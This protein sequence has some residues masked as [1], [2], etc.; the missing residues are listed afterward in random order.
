MRTACIAAIIAAIL[1]LPAAG[2]RASTGVAAGTSGAD[3]AFAAAVA[4]YVHESEQRDPLFA[5]SLGINT[6]DDRLTDYSAAAIAADD[7][8]SAAWR[9]KFASFDPSSLNAD[10]A[11]DRRQVLDQIDGSTFDERAL[12]TWQTD[13]TIYVGAIGD[14]A[15]LLTS[16]TYASP[17]VRMRS[18]LARMPLIPS[19]VKDAEANLTRPPLVFTQ[20]AIQQNLGNID[21]YTNDV[22]Q[23]A[24][25]ASPSLHAAYLKQLPRLLASLDEL[26]HFLTGPLLQR[27]DGNPRVGA[28][29]FAR[30]L[31]LV[32]GTDTPPSVLVARAKQ[33]FEATRRQMLQLALPLDKQLFPGKVHHETGDALI[34]A[35]VG[36][37]LNRLA[38]DHPT[39]DQ[40][41]DT[42][43]ADVAKL[44]G[45]LQK[46]PVVPLPVP[47][48][49]HVVPTPPFAA[50]VAGAGLDPA[51][52]FTPLAGSNY[53]IDQIPSAWSQ[54]QVTSYLRDY[55]D[56]E[57]QILSL[58][59]A[60][61]GHYVQ[62]RYNAAVPSLV[63]RVWPNGSFVE[64][65]AVYTEGMMLDSG[66]G[67]GDPRLKLFQL[68][69]RLRE[70]SNTIIDNEYHTAGLTHAQCVAFLEQGA[71]QDTAQAETKWHRLEVSHDQLS[72]Y[73]VGLDAITQAENARRAALGS[74]FSVA[75]YNA[76]LLR[77]GSVEPRSVATLIS[78][79]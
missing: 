69:W 61:P 51:G 12:H 13:P 22:A 73:F 8:W 52:P 68:K 38:D 42:A 47:D 26:Q 11:A 64:G 50:G 71:F 43:K 28:A 17:A 48:T 63:R 74:A 34:D 37:V 44:M 72:S 45:F 6:Y 58:H 75:S 36:E 29:V 24:A 27:S 39:R 70:Y 55:N 53:D 2:S 33:N 20:L 54:A 35:V 4:Q 31:Q 57:M 79:R 19:Y 16:R 7:T 67:G 41:F 9:A 21:F 15:F 5:D 25:Q 78:Q 60:V 32:D 56:Y 3:A 18:V 30:D 46:D 40:V 59:E 62:F 1:M 76:A 66:F 77:M 14:A 65:W 10:D 23:F 49:L